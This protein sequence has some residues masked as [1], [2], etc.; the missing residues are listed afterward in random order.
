MILRR[1]AAL[2]GNWLDEADPRIVIRGIDAGVPHESIQ[3][4]NRMSGVGQ[5]VTSEHFETLDVVITFAIMVPRRDLRTRREVFETAV[6]WAM[7]RGWL[8]VN[9][10]ADNRAQQNRRMHVDKVII[11]SAG[12]MWNW[13]DEYAI[14]LRAYNV[15]FW[16]EINP[17][18][19]Q[20]QNAGNGWHGQIGVRGMFR[21]V[22]DVTFKNTSGSTLNNFAVTTD[23]NQIML[24]NLGLPNNQAVEFVHEADGLLR[25]QTRII[26]AQGQT[27]ITSVYNKQKTGGA[28]DLYMDPGTKT[29][30]ITTGGNGVLT[31]SVYG[32]YP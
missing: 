5:R 24:E 16:Q 22:A 29:V 4:M 10:M 25:I 13:T 8:T 12:D 7:Q 23:G 11:P 31:V 6:G 1:R 30:S 20:V 14:T 19:I 17:A 3:A 28:E 15:P 21:T 18:T 9:Y 27:T 32:R 26:N 2:N